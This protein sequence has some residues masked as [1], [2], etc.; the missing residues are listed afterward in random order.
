MRAWPFGPHS[1]C[2]N[3][4]AKAGLTLVYRAWDPKLQREAAVKLLLA[5]GTSGSG[6]YQA[7]LREARL[8]AKVMAETISSLP[9]NKARSPCFASSALPPKTNA[10]WSSTRV[11]PCPGLT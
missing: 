8:T 6:P 4:P 1:N 7:V 2:A 11:T 3:R 5:S 9:W 10:A